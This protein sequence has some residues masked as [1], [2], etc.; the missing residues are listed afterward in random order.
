MMIIYHSP[1][2]KLSN[3]LYNNSATVL[4]LKILPR[5]NCRESNPIPH[6]QFV[7]LITDK[8]RKSKTCTTSIVRFNL[9]VT[10]YL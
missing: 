1:A 7:T 10:R 2:T 4:G 9:T 6:P 5:R 3:V 8:I